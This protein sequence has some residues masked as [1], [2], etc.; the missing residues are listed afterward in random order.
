MAQSYEKSATHPKNLTAPKHTQPAAL[1]RLARS[2]KFSYFCGTT[3]SMK[4]ALSTLLLILCCALAAVARPGNDLKFKQIG[5]RQG[6]SHATVSSVAQDADGYMWVATADGLDRYDGY[7][8][9][10]YRHSDADSTSLPA[11]SP[12]LLRT[13]R[14]GRLWIVTGPTLSL[15]DR[16]HDCF[17]NHTLNAPGKPE[18]TDILP[19]DDGRLLAGTSRGIYVFDPGKGTFSRPPVRQLDDKE[20]LALASNGKAVFV[21]SADGRVFSM[22]AGGNGGLREITLP[23]NPQA[24][25]LLPDGDRYLLVGTEGS[26][27]LRHDLVTGA[28]H[29]YRA[30]GPEGLGSDY[31][32]SMALDSR[33]RVWVGTFT[34]L[35]VL[36]AARDS[37]T[38]YDPRP[39][40]SGALSHSSVRCIYT[41]NQGGMWLGTYFG[42]LNYHHPLRDQFH[43]L[44]KSV[45]RASLNDNVI[46][47]MAEDSRGHIWIGTNSGGLNRYTPADGAWEHITKADGLGSNDVKAIYIDP[48]SGRM[49]VGCHLGGLNVIDGDARASRVAPEVQNVFGIAPARKPGSLWLAA[50]DGLLLY[51]TAS[52]KVS[53]RVDVGLAKA[54]DLMRDSDG[55]LWVSGEDGLRVM[56]DDAA[57]HLAPAADAPAGLPA[58]GTAVYNVYQSRDGKSF[59]LSTDKGLWQIDAAGRAKGRHFTTADSALPNDM[60]FGVLEDAD[61]HVWCSTNRGLACISPA[62]GAMRTYG[63]RDGLQ[64]NQ[65]MPKSFLRASDGRLYFGGVE[66]LS[67]FN[68]ALLE[69]NPYA[70]A[71]LITELRLFNKPVRAGDDTGLLSRPISQTDKITLGVNQTVFTID[72]TVCNYLAGEHN[73]FAYKLEGLDKDW[74]TTDGAGSVTYSNLPA[75]DYRF[76][77]RAA[78]NDGLWSDIV[79]SLDI[80]ILPV[81]YKR[82]W[83]IVLFV[84]LG[85]GA[86]VAVFRYLW[87]KRAMEEQLR[88]ER[89]DRERQRELHEMKVRFFI[90][91]SHE[92][93]TPLTLIL[94][95]IE[96]LLERAADPKTVQKLKTIRNNASR[97]LHIVNQLLDYRRAEMGMFRLAVE[98]VVI[99]DLARAT[100]ANYDYQAQ[101]RGI[102]YTLESDV[103][104]GTTVMCDP[105]YLE[106]IFN[107]LLSNAFKYTPR[108]QSIGVRLGLE[109]SGPAR[110]LTISVTDTG[111]GIPAEK[112]NDIFTRF[113]QVGDHAGGSGIGLSLVKRLVELH[114]GTIEVESSLG[115]G[116]TFTV[117]LPADAAAYSSD[118]TS[119]GQPL[120]DAAAAKAPLVI[121]EYMPDDEG[122][123]D[124]DDA[125][126]ESDSEGKRTIMVVDDN[127]E[128]LKYLCESLAADYNVVPAADGAKAIQIMS[129][130]SIDLIITDV[131]MPDI[132]GMQ[133]CRTVKRNLRTS[134]IPVI[135]LSAKNDIADQLGGLKVGADDYIAKPFSMPVL[136]AKIKNQLRTRDQAVRH[137]TDTAAIEPEKVTINPLDEA[138]LKKAMEVMEKHLDDSEFSTNT[139]ASE[140]CMSRSNLHL[141]MKALTGESTNDF[142]RRF[143]LR[144]ALDLLKSGRYTVSEVSA[145]VGYGTPSYFAT[146]FKKFFGSLPSEFMRKD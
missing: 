57:G 129:Q 92:L 102:R 24:R 88:M 106:L 4:N 26:G 6:L 39:D 59:W 105:Q 138:F 54:T 1:R 25:V 100:F 77:L 130:Q 76:L 62:D 90:N 145:M 133:L 79:T 111:C 118:E 131:M 143:R 86:V 73:T 58:P 101:R 13:D 125:A 115:D 12:R 42:G 47:T 108:G 33:G 94:L 63:A 32:R 69:T 122:D 56:R 134:H 146:S 83:A 60:V 120:P 75:G 44:R 49:Y 89:H 97:I 114:H 128:I 3:L 14:Q 7:S 117:S 66:G 53:G 18:I 107:N 15:Y 36:D 9:R 80:T 45:L 103:P 43:T 5:I 104:D 139:F 81:W 67:Y 132:D 74:Y 136:A 70:P 41:D 23:G 71:P 68:P 20:V 31:V 96:E 126:A 113:Y 142:I 50:L 27:L 8:F 17:R 135:I 55:R 65:F 93:R 87:H 51:D 28:T 46:S 141:K 10:V 127:P 72:F 37:F 38:L 29:V 2:G 35:A 140:M 110:R 121:P 82:W 98:P 61:G 91:M 99:N 112:L 116:T 22:A 48:A 40:S 34:G 109:G 144:R 19:L 85:A 21:G 119:A 124:E 84:L 30:G 137:F 11:N 52:G 64:S 16:D 95:P 78:N 123:A